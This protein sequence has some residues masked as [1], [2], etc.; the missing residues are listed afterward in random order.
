MTPITHN[1]NYSIDADG[2]VFSHKSGRIL[3]PELAKNGYK[4]ITLCNHVNGKLKI[5]RYLLHRLVAEHFVPNPNNLPNVNHIDNDRSNAAASNLEWCTHS[6]NM[7]HC[8]KQG[9]CSNIAASNAAKEKA[10]A[11]TVEKFK[12]LLGENFIEYIPASNRKGGSIKFKCKQCSK[13]YIAR[14]D[15]STFRTKCLCMSCVR[16]RYSLD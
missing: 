14:T 8:H 15:S 2:N 13:P 3:K 12:S 10:I 6:D 7:R 11:G 16:R 5:T 4:R 1:S 9:R